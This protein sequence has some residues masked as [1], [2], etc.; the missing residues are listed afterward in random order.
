MSKETNRKVNWT[1]EEE[2]TLIEAIQAAG[3]VLRG[4]SQSADINKK[5]TRLWNDVINKINSIHGNNRDMKEVKKKWNS[6]KGSAKAR[7]DCSRREARRT[8]GGPNVGGEVEDEDILI[9]SSDKE[10]STWATERVS[11]M[12]SRT[13]AFTGISG[14]V[15]LFQPPTALLPQQTEI[16]EA[17]DVTPVFDGPEVDVSSRPVGNRKRK[18]SI[19]QP[20]HIIS[21]CDLLPLQQEVLWKQMEVLFYMVTMPPTQ[22]RF[23]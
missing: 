21:V 8:V 18:R 23:E 12:L 13:P 17:S 11:Q 16:I 10:M 22:N 19:E 3:D 14:S 1:K 7:V 2:Y 20:N 6:L 9:L 5:K 15:D 4:T